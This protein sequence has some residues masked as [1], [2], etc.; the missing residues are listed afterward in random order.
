MNN[1]DKSNRAVSDKSSAPSPA[2]IL[3]IESATGV[4]SVAVCSR[5]AVKAIR[6]SGD[7]RAHS[8]L[9]ATFVR[10]VLEEAGTMSSGLAAVAVSRGPGS[11][12]GLRIGVSMAKGLAY[13][14]GISLISADTLLSMYHS[15]LL[16]RPEFITVEPGTLF[17]P[18]IDARRMEVYNSVIAPG[19]EVQKEA[20]ATVVE[21]ETFREILDRGP[22]VFFGNGAAKC[23]E[24]ITHSNALFIDDI[25]P[26]AAGM[27][28]LAFRAL[29]ESGFEDVAY[30]EPYYLKDFLATIPKKLIP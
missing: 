8:R 21:A 29:D 4:C 6:E 23:K 19:G 12:T 16:T 5:T 28:N 10:E 15:L 24:V 9:L 20:A 11:Y 26:S 27:K 22:V 7:E 2:L 17:I 30:F 1:K 18:M 3:C 13:G 14:A 25:H